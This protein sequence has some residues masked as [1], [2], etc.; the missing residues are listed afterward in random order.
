MRA[1][2]KGNKMGKVI[3]RRF[4]LKQDQA[5]IYIAQEIEILVL[6]AASTQTLSDVLWSSLN[7]NGVITLITITTNYYVK[8]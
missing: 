1:F 3:L 2:W 8:Q 4:N 6:N 5:D 7:L